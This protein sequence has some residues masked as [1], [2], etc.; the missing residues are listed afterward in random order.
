MSENM[1]EECG[2]FGV[3]SKKPEKLAYM[4]C[5]G[6]SGLQHRGEESCGIAVNTDGVIA[7]H[8]DQ[9]LV[10]EVF[11]NE[12]LD[13]LPAG[14]M[15]IGHVRYSTTGSA[16]KE[17][18]QPMVIRHKKGNL[19]VA[20]NGNITNAIELKQDLEDNG[21]IFTTTNDTEVICHIIVRE[22]LKA[23]STEEA[24]SN[25]MKVL[26]GAYSLVIMSPQKLIAA[27]DP[28]GFKPLC[29]G[30]LGEDIIFASESCALDICG[31]EF[32]RDVKPGEIIVVKDGKI[33]SIDYDSK[34][35]KGMCVFEY[36]YFARP[37]SIL[38]GMSV[39][40]FREKAGRYLAKQM[41]IDADI[42][43]AVPD[44]GVD[45][46]LGYSKESKIPYDLVFTKSKYIGR[47]FIQNTQNKRKKLVALKLNPLK[48]SIRGKRIVLIDDSIVRGNTLAGIVKT[49][50]KSGA[51][52]VHLRIASP[53]FIDI[54]YFGTDIDDK[55]S[56][57]AN[58][59]S[60]EEIRQIIGADTLEYL[61]IENL[62]EITKGCNMEDFCM[63]CFTGKYPIEV[64]KEIKKDRF[65]EKIKK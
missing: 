8:K 48:N 49:L 63:G 16:K 57:I 24:I 53:A 1:K 29:M 60:V 4:T 55:E 65:E 31:A 10:S 3:Y 26:K 23:K 37:D 6:L 7:Y 28:Q 21:A 9:G 44:S 47:T 39:H 14:N 13:N 59:R 46:A 58:G 51:K 56:L 34:E 40:E 2:I 32:I 25:T 15:S 19:A 64:P 54:C 43:A 62:K 20:H 5:V 30:K 27:R 11:T 41:P 33:T 18:A 61:S 42:V 22:R 17:N 38:E 45:A 35:K 50:R 52:E 36:I 12:V